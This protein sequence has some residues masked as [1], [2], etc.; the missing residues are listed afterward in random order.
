MGKNMYKIFDRFNN[1]QRSLLLLL[2]LGSGVTRAQEASQGNTTLFNGAEMTVFGNYHFATGGAGT[3]PGIVATLRTAPF[4][5]LQFANAS[6]VV[7]GAN[8]ANHIDGYVSNLGQGKFVYPVGDN[9]KYAPFAATA[10]NTVGAYFSADPNV[11]V[12][13]LVSGGNYAALPTGAPFSTDNVAANMAAV[14]TKEYWDINGANASAITLT[15][16][17]ASDVAGLTS[18]ELQ[19][20]TIAGW[21]A[22]TSQWELISSAV[23]GT[24]LLGG[25]SSLTS[26]SITTLTDIVPNTYS[27]YTLASGI[28]I[29]PNLTVSVEIDNQN[30]IAGQSRDFA[31]YLFETNDVETSGTVMVRIARVSGWDIKIPDI[32]LSATNQ[33]GTAGSVAVNGGTP[34]ENEKWLFRQTS[35]FIIA[36]LKPEYTISNYGMSTLG[37]VA[38]VKEGTTV[39]TLQSINAILV[40]GSGGEIDNT[41]NLFISNLTFN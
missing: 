23:D 5:V 13:S 27:V 32:E 41:D 10:A 16:N 4:G 15:W 9:G 12:T 28:S 35:G 2:L 18:N 39:G 40:D 21:N 14:S 19:N 29:V 34:H 30:F 20:L 31:L 8:D 38:T 7:N 1:G 6:L 36:T 17:E 24:S 37:L 25:E 11:A 22:T 26:G 3:Q 33:S